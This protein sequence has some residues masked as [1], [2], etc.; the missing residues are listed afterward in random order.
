VDED[1]SKYAKEFRRQA[2]AFRSIAKVKEAY[3]EDEK[4]LGVVAV[5]LG[6]AEVCDMLAGAQEADV[7]E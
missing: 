2:D 3:A 4:D 5:A 6:L 1:R 7:D